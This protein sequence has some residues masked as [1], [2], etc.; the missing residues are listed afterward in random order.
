MAQLLAVPV[1]GLVENTFFIFP[2]TGKKTEIFGPSHAAETAQRLGIPFLGQ[3][4]LNPQ[5]TRLCDAGAI[6]D[7]SGEE[8][9]P[10]VERL[11]QAAI[12]QDLREEAPNGTHNR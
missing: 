12:R 7:Y 10:L 6:E 9:T 4:P 8:F 1:L 3:L 5:I 2:Y 11:R